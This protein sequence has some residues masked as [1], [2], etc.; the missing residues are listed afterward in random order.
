MAGGTELEGTSDACRGRLHSA[1]GPPCSFA[2]V[3][4][5]HTLKHWGHGFP[6]S[7]YQAAV[8][9]STAKTVLCE[10]DGCAKGYLALRYSW[11]TGSSLRVVEGPPTKGR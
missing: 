3:L 1:W 10:A 9:R 4:A 6:S 8:V 2:S 7:I 11:A 5:P